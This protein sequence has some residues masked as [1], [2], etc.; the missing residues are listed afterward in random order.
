MYKLKSIAGLMN[1]GYGIFFSL[2]IGSFLSIVFSYM[3]QD[4]WVPQVPFKIDSKKLACSKVI[5]LER[6]YTEWRS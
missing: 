4:S 2:T 1:L 5:I 3:E 6:R